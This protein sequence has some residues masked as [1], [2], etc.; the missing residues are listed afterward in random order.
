MKKLA[1]LAL[2]AVVLWTLW[3]CESPFS[4]HTSPEFGDREKRSSVTP[5]SEVA[6]V[7][8]Q[9]YSSRT[10][11]L[12]D[13]GLSRRVQ[14][15][16]KNLPGV[17]TVGL[18][19]KSQLGSWD[20]LPATFQR[21]VNGGTE[22]LWQ[23]DFSNKSS[24]YN[25]QG[26]LILFDPC[27]EYALKYQV[28]GQTFWDNNGGK[29]YTKEPL[30][31]RFWVMG[32]YTPGTYYAP[33]GIKAYVKNLTY[34]KKVTL[35]YSTDRWATTQTLPGVFSRQDMGLDLWS[36]PGLSFPS[37]T[38][39]DFAIAYDPQGY[40]TIWDNNFGENYRVTF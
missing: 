3:S 35:V 29:N 4:M 33:A 34:Q 40:G 30:G 31:A 37:G 26:G 1:P 17:K 25:D 15:I 5:T 36:F 22:E 10:P 27:V 2:M 7:S 12:W 9:V 24:Y 18:W 19:A 20:L 21:Q 6:L 14:I 38:V 11:Y 13:D 23:A 16:V 32:I 28:A 8:Y 39:V